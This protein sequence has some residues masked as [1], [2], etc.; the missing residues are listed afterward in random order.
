MGTCHEDEDLLRLCRS[1]RAPPTPLLPNLFGFA[2]EPACAQPGG[3]EFGSGC[4]GFELYCELVQRVCPQELFLP[5]LPKAF[6]ITQHDKPLAVNGKV[7]YYLE[8]RRGN[9]HYPLASRRGR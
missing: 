6:Q 2:R 5:D 3:V 4:V 9:C 7:Q 8:D 1:I